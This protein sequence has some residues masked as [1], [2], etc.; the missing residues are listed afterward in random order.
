MSGFGEASCREQAVSLL[1][2]LWHCQGCKA[3]YRLTREL[4]RDSPGGAEGLFRRDDGRYII[5][6]VIIAQDLGE[7]IPANRIDRWDDPEL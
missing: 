1:H 2:S 7:G 4:I 3:R 6:R 5:I